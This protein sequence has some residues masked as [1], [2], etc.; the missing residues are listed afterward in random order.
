MA[1]PTK[2]ARRRPRQ[3]Q[4]RR[5]SSARRQSRTLAQPP[6][7]KPSVNNPPLWKRPFLWIGALIAAMALAAATALG[8][9]LGDH[10]FA[11]STPASAP[12]GPP[13]IVNSGQYMQGPTQAG[14]LAFAKPLSPQEVAFY[15][16]P[17]L[18]YQNYVSHA[19]AVGGAGVGGVLL[20]IVLRGNYPGLAVVSD[21]QVVRRCGPPLDGTLLYSPP[22]A[23]GTNIGIGFN[24]D[25]QFATAQDYQTNEPL[26]GN[27]FAEHTISL[28]KGQSE[29]LLI[30]AQTTD[31]YCQFTL[32]LV[33]DV[34]RA[35]Y[36]QAQVVE[37]ISNHGQ[38]FAV[39][40]ALTGVRNYLP[41]FSRYAVVYAAG[42]ASPDPGHIVRVNPKTWNGT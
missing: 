2:S 29:G 7:E 16:T 24:L 3:N 28:T 34:V 18:N 9:G 12:V 40:A 1:R 27:F 31:H 26:S 11:D 41:T 4:L 13:V 39:T 14:T 20:A 23:E 32:R 36:G 30:D 17:Y 38:P 6:A 37:S 5:T 21:L 8:T 25:S 19:T 22:A 35:D 10:L 42:V 33:V 15:N